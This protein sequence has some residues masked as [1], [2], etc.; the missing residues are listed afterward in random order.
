MVEVEVGPVLRQ[1]VGIGE[2]GGRILGRV[3]R[4]RER[5]VDGGAD[6]VV[7]EVGGARLAAPLADVDG[8]ADALVAVVRDR[9]DLALAHGHALADGLRH[10]GF[11]RRRARLLRAAARMRSATRVNSSVET[12]N[13]PSARAAAARSS[14]AG[15]SYRGGRER[16]SHVGENQGRVPAA[17]RLRDSFAAWAMIANAVF[18]SISPCPPRPIAR[19]RR[20]DAPEAP[21]SRHG[22]VEDA[23][24][25]GH[26]RAA[27]PRRGA[28]RARALD[29]SQALDLPER[30]ADAIAQAR[31][32]TKHEARRRQMQFVGR[33]MRD[34]DPGADPR[35]ARAHAG[36]AARGARAVRGR[37][38][39][40]R[41]LARRRARRRRIRRRASRTRTPHAWPRSMREARGERASG[42]PPHKFRALF[43]FVNHSVGR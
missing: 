32:I 43:R 19:S 23:A 25:E 4:D 29:G 18:S 21:A 17:R 9:L 33:L 2:A 13:G 6:R 34:V 10:L 7:A 14:G 5:L 31:S 15:A 27:G 41:P 11:G 24:Q 22:A 8:D 26:A 38:T 37:R 36:A 16:G 42:R 20:T 12:G 1:A 39:L 3:A 40:A 30:L 35:R 28:R